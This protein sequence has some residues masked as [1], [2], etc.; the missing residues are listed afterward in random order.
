MLKKLW[1][2]YKSYVIA[3]S[4][5]FAL[6]LIMWIFSIP[7]PI[8]YITGTSCAGCGMS[9]AIISALTLDFANAFAYHP[10]WIVI[11]P[12]ILVIVMLS[13]KGKSKAA[14]IVFY[15]LAGLFLAVW[16]IRLATGDSVVAF[17]PDNSLINQVIRNIFDK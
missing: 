13:A 3:L 6:V 15:C 14:G 17:D 2:E 10:L 16:I 11:I 9:R 12:A 7:C 8:K 5:V 4:S 1:N